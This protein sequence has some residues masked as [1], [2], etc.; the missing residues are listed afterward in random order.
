MQPMTKI[1]DVQEA[2]RLEEKGDYLVSVK[3]PSKPSPPG[4]GLTSHEKAE[5]PSSLM[6][7]FGDYRFIPLNPLDFLNHAGAELLLIEK[8]SA[9]MVNKESEIQ[10][11]LAHISEED[12]SKQMETF[13][14]TETVEPLFQG[15]F[16]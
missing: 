5:Y 1:G 4:V 2:F 11:C 14:G 6:Q 12:I 15:K 13:E 10:E 9:K 3:N 7:K 8:G 16:K